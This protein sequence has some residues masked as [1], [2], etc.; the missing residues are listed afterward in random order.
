MEN[1]YLVKTDAQVKKMTND[2]VA[3]AAVK[4]T[5]LD[6]LQYFTA[7]RTLKITSNLVTKM[8][9]TQLKELETVEMNFNCVNSL[10]LSNNTKLTRFRYGGTT[11][12]PDDTKLSAISF[13]TNTAIEHI[14]LKD[15]NIAKDAFELPT[16]YSALK[17]L[18]LSNNPGAP[19]TIPEELMKQLTTAKGVEAPAEP[20]PE[21]E[22]KYYTIGDKAFAEYIYYLANTAGS[23]PKEIMVIEDGAYRLDKEVAATVTV[24]NVSK[25]S[26]A[27][28]K[29]TEAGVATASTLINNA[30]GLQFFTA[31]TEFTGTSNNF[32]EPLPLTALTKLEVLQVNTAGVSALDLSACPAL[33]T[34]NCNGS[35]K[36][37]YG[38]L[39]TIDLS[40]NN[41]IETLNLKNNNISEINLSNLTSLKDVDLSGNPGADFKIPAAIYN[42]LK[43]AKGVVFE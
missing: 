24:L 25:A 21:P 27:I 22:S 10:D 20:E 40:H 35:T 19:F 36:G 8:D 29:L 18:D 33:K 3:T 12:A 1:L 17:E 38:K 43:T 26:S 4:I 30:D 37:G 28:K 6:G 5:N 23:L 32:T 15:Q 34:L 41:N 9:L 2:G 39:T 31:L 7:L 14:Y 42:N 11:D 13:L 16:D